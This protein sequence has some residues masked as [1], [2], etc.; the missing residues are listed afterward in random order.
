MSEKTK[1]KPSAKGRKE[2]DE[3][4][5]FPQASTTC[6]VIR[7][8]EAHM[9][10]DK[11]C[12]A[13]WTRESTAVTASI[14]LKPWLFPWR[15]QRW[16]LGSTLMMTRSALSIYIVG[17]AGVYG[18]STQRLRE[19]CG[20]DGAVISEVDLNHNQLLHRNREVSTKVELSGERE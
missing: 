13:K 16:L 3:H 5:E 7:S 9:G 2:N 19:T 18:A 15:R 20:R 17:S 14:Y 1:G 6:A 10:L 4:G 12:T 8:T 11:K